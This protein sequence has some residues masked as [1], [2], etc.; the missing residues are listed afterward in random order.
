MAT[1][2]QQVIDEV[3]PAVGEVSPRKLTDALLIRW[4]HQAVLAI[5]HKFVDVLQEKYLSEQTV[6]TS[7]ASGGTKNITLTNALF[8]VLKVVTSTTQFRELELLEVEGFQVNANFASSYGWHTLTESSV[9]LVK[10]SSASVQASVDVTGVKKPTAITLVT[11]TLDIPDEFHE[12]VI[13]EVKK[14]GYEIAEKYDREQITQQ[15]IVSRIQDIENSFRVV[16][17]QA[18]K[19]KSLGVGG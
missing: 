12:L 18:E 17:A 3:R 1:T 16:V 10:G 6:S 19:G 5:F 13:L 8:K 9:K 4:T 2:V 7:W 15:Q 11:D 14:K